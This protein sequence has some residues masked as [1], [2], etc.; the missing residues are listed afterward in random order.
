MNFKTLK[1]LKE[2][3]EAPEWLEQPGYKTLTEGYLLSE[4]TPKGMW[5][6]LAS[7][8]AAIL[9]KPEKQ[10]AFFELFWKNW[11]CPASPVASNFGT[12]K[13]LPISCYGVNTHDS[14]DGIFK[15]YHEIAMLTKNGGGIG[16]NYGSVRGREAEISNG[17]KSRGIIPWLKILDSIMIG[18]SQN[19]TRR[20]AAAVY[21]PIEHPDWEEFL[22]MR[23]PVGDINRRC[24]NLHHGFDLSDEFMYSLSDSSSKVQRHKYESI[25]DTRLNVG[26]PFIFYSG[27]ANKVNPPW[28]KKHNLTVKHT[29]LCTE[30]MLYNSEEETYVC[31][32]SSM[33]LVKWDEWKD[34]DAIELSIEFLDAVMSEFI[35]KA[36]NL[37]GFAKAVRFA[38]KNRALGLG[39]LGWHS[40]LQEKFIEF[41]SLQAYLLNKQIFKT[42]KERA[43]IATRRLAVEYGEPEYCKGFGVR[44]THLLAVAPTSSNSTISGGWSPGIEPYN[45]NVNS[46]KTSKGTFIIKNKFLEKLLKSKKMNTHE[47]WTKINEDRGSVQYLDFLSPEEKAVFKTARELNQHVLIKLAADRQKYIDQGQSLNLFF[48]DTVDENYFHEVHYEAWKQGLKSLYY[49]R[50]ESGLRGDSAYK[51]ASDCSYCEG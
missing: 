31:C 29:Q 43:E 46:L 41:E 37:P 6:R 35:E 22:N 34:T 49:V 42:M 21:L 18:V 47:V 23:R 14:I 51:S 24:L 50:A 5:M 27:N 44:N 12:S 30:I 26:E 25:L 3:N 19:D 36:K 2:L 10:Q 45:A 20:G 8:A 16:N 39:V 11:L 28:Y 17:G 40:L 4:E 48:S 13:G 9:K 1:E 32:L 7:K 33:N 38:E 15:S